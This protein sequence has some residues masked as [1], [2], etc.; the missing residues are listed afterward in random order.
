MITNTKRALG[1]AAAIGAAAAAAILASHAIAQTKAGPFTEAQATAGQP[2]YVGKCSACH[3]AG[4]E[5]AKLIGPSFTQ[6][7]KARSTKDLYTRIKTTMPFSNPGS[8]SEAE[9]TAVVAYILKSNGATACDAHIPAAPS[10][11]TAPNAAN[12]PMEALIITCT[13]PVA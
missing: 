8:L 4:G 11:R 3:D 6:G 10:A 1:A 7:W 9:A 13:A 5:T 2:V 12:A